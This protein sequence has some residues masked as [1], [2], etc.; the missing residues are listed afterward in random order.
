[1]DLHPPVYEPATRRSSRLI[2]AAAGSTSGYRMA[3]A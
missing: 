3:S 2:S 1:M